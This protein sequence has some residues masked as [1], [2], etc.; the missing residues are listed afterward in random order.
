MK[1]MISATH[2]VAAGIIA[3]AFTVGFISGPAFAQQAETFGFKFKY[4]QSELGSADSARKLLARLESQ[5][6]KFCKNEAQTGSRLKKA[7][8]ACVT[9]T[10]DQTVASFGSDTVAQVYKSRTNG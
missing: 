8:P 6:T 5:V 9:A 10:M 2:F 7:D 3:G 1:S 4:E